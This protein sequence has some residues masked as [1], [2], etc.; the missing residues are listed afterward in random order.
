MDTVAL[1]LSH[2]STLALSLGG[3]MHNIELERIF[4][5]R[6]YD[7]RHERPDLNELAA[8]VH[9]KC[10]HFETALLVGDEDDMARDLF[11]LIGAKSFEKVDH[12]ASHGAAAFYESPFDESLVVSYDGGGND[13]TFRTFRAD[14]DKGLRPFDGGH[15]LNLGIPYRALA[16]PIAEINKPTDGKERSNAGK[17][18]GLAA[19]GQVRHEWISAITDYFLE[20]SA[21][22]GV[23]QMYL[24]VLGCLDSLGKR[25]GLNMSRNALADNEGRDLACT[26]QHIFESIFLKTILPIATQQKV[27]I[28]VT[29]GCALNVI[30]NQKLA[31]SFDLPIF[32]PP[33]P[34]D[35]GLAQG[36]ILLRSRPRTQVN[37]TYSGISAVDAS[38]LSDAV[39]C[40]GAVECTSEELAKLLYEGHVVAVMRRESEHGPRALGNRS[41]L[42][43]PSIPGMRGRLNERIKFREGFRPYAPVVRKQ[44]IN[45][46]FENAKN[47]MSFMSFNPTVRSAWRTTMAAAVHVDR[48]AR[49]QTVT[50]QQNPWLY[51]L[52]TEFERLSGF[53]VLVNTSFN[54]KGRPMVTA[55]KDALDLWLNTDLNCL[56]IESWLFRKRPPA[57][58]DYRR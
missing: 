57:A 29:G 23:P 42:C 12:H 19:Y 25:I 54:S 35:C 41:I 53:G 43:N 38:L 44:D 49:A 7:A 26:A 48:T 11:A 40:Y 8:L 39:A 27:P 24:M 3:E 18:M 51:D 16:H 32:V 22:D 31:D 50:R 58:P 34:N 56:V 30:T 5:K 1:H 6:H 46:F 17:L 33:N 20:F 13:G 45:K 28:C 55:V 52:L 15:R 21:K 2:D 37:V 10:R 9:R 4:G 47:D 14:R 36:A